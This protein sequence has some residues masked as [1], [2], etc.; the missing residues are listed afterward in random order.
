MDSQEK[1]KKF[2]KR[3]W[4]WVIVVLVLVVIG[5]SGNSNPPAQTAETAPTTQAAQTETAS[6]PTQ[7]AVAPT[8]QAAPVKTASAP[9]PAP[10]PAPAPHVPQVLLQVS[11]SG[12]KSTQTFMAPST[13]TLDY[14]YDCS[15]FGSQGNFQIFIFNGSGAMVPLSGPNQLGMS[16]SDTEYYHSGGQ[17]YL[18]INSECSWTVTAKG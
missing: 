14:S 7:A 13:W 12:S 11:G 9:T 17:L 18:E 2:Y 1:P 5:E 15:S 8:K 4:F 10:A 6:A 16:G 3:W